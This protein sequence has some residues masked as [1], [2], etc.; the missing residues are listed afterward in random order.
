MASLLIKGGRVID[1]ASGVDR[2]ADVAIADG[3][4]AAVGQGSKGGRLNGSGAG[5]VIDAA[6]CIVTPGLIDPHVHLREPGMED[7]ETI[8]SG[9]AAAV[10]GGFTTICCMPN[11]TPP[12]DEDSMIEFIFKQTE[13]T[14]RCRVYPVGAISKGRRGEELA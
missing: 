4:V 7:A 2:V 14:G 9:T 12:L 5:R 8:A 1:P 6:G 3:I 11:T 10:Q 13:T